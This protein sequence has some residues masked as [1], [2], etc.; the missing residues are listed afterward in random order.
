[1]KTYNKMNFLATA[2]IVAVLFSSCTVEYRTRHPRRVHVYGV[3]QP[4][5]N[6]RPL[7]AV[8]PESDKNIPYYVINGL[9]FPTTR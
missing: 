7:V 3:V 4:I 6:Q 8:A 1:M 9:S 5:N 2:A